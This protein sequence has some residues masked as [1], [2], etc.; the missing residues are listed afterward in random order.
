MNLRDLKIDQDKVAFERRRIRKFEGQLRDL[1]AKA[2]SCDS[3]I[4]EAAWDC[5]TAA[6]GPH[7]GD[8]RMLAFKQ[9]RAEIYE[10]VEAEL[11][12]GR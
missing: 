10:S 11:D 3:E 2:M 4:L 12:E 1:K 8:P 5:A 7:C 9:L 6:E